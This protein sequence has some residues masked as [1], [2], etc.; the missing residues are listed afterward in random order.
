MILNIAHLKFSLFRSVYKIK[1]KIV[2]TFVI[3]DNE[4]NIES[5]TI[6]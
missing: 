6:K 4:E 3:V 1:N 2:K 5:I